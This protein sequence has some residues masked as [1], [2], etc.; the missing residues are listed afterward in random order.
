MVSSCER[1]IGVVMSPYSLRHRLYQNGENALE[2]RPDSTGWTLYGR[3]RLGPR[4]GRGGV[5]G[6]S[7]A[8]DRRLRRLLIAAIE[9]ADSSPGV[10]DTVRWRWTGSGVA[11]R[12]LGAVS[13]RT[14]ASGWG[15]EARKT[16][17][18]AGA[19]GSGG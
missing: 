14:S 5:V 3:R 1:V 4:G 18:T 9:R 15:P 17:S 6:G 19:A 13:H 11:G 8:N 2:A 7:A 10:I 16:K 12:V